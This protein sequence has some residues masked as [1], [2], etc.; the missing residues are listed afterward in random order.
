MSDWLAP[1][2]VEMPG[3][4][5]KVLAKPAPTGPKPVV[6]ELVNFSYEA[7]KNSLSFQIGPDRKK[8]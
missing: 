4:L 6:S 5:A 8:P 3:I 1:A 7:A 2:P